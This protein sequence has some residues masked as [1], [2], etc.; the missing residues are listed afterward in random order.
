MEISL[1][2]GEATCK[3]IFKIP[4]CNLVGRSIER[5]L[6]SPLVNKVLATPTPAM[7]APTPLI[8]ATHSLS[9]SRMEIKE[10][11]S[12]TRKE[13][14]G[15]QTN[16][17]SLSNKW[18]LCRSSGLCLSNSCLKRAVFQPRV[19]FLSPIKAWQRSRAGNRTVDRLNRGRWAKRTLKRSPKHGRW[20]QQTVTGKPCSATGTHDRLCGSLR[21]RFIKEL[22]VL[23]APWVESC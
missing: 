18:L 21:S 10:I 8:S 20:H 4:L 19:H 23:S 7:I 13:L 11:A 12:R 16:D 6:K 9:L 2:P 17:P 15:I 1:L 22:S 14:L 5:P 3:H